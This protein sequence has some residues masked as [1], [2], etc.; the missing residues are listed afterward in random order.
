[1][2]F[3]PLSA[4]AILALA[5]LFGLPFWGATPA[6]SA[7]MGQCASGGA[8]APG[9]PGAGGHD[10]GQTAPGNPEPVVEAKETTLEGEVVD[11]QCFMTNS[12]GSRGPDHAKCAEEC[13]AKGLPIGFVS[14]GRIYLLLGPGKDPA[15]GIAA[16]RT[17]TTVVIHGKVFEQGGLAAIQAREIRPKA[18]GAAKAPLPVPATKSDATQWVCPMKCE[19]S[20]TYPAPG[21]CPVCGMMLNKQKS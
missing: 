12:V 2:K 3:M 13:I 9:G 16:G 15:K 1:M 8:S 18:E 17:G 5:L 21:K 11:L 10:H 14:G 20:K 7:A 4:I 19:G 6:A